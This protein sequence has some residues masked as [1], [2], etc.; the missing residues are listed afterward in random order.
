MVVRACGTGK[1]KLN[2]GMIGRKE[3]SDCFLVRLVA[4][5]GVL[6]KDCLLAVRM[7]DGPCCTKA[8]F[9]WALVP[10]DGLISSGDIEDSEVVFLMR[11]G[12]A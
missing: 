12:D 5:E 11:G 7:G 6:V 8:I 10:A 2:D 1:L 3:N 9:S 4:G